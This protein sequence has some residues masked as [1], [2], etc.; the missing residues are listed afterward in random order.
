MLEKKK[1]KNSKKLA[2]NG[3]TRNIKEGEEIRKNNNEDASGVCGK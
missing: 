2:T 3:E 1:A